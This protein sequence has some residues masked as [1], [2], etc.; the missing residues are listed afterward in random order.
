MT[1]SES[2]LNLKSHRYQTEADGFVL[3]GDTAHEQRVAA[4]GNT[5]DAEDNQPLEEPGHSQLRGIN[6]QMNEGTGFEILS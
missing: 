2:L 5:S 1:S 3:L 4:R 6:P